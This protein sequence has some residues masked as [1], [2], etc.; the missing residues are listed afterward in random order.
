MIITTLA[1][2]ALAPG[3]NAP[4]PEPDI[5]GPELVELFLASPEFSGG[6]CD[7]YGV[8]MAALAGMDLPPESAAI[9]QDAGDALIIVSMEGED[10]RFDNEA[11]DVIVEWLHSDCAI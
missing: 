3:V 10:Q 7:A 2:L 11:R 5:V 1:V 4:T 6:L 8:F 9:F